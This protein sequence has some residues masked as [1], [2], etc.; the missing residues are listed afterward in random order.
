M[1]DTSSSCS[2]VIKDAI[3]TLLQLLKGL[4]QLEGMLAEVMQITSNCQ[5]SIVFNE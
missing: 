1:A 3:G 5:N 2:L 4:C